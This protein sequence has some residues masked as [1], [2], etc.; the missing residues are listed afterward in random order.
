MPPPV[1]AGERWPDTRS[2]LNPL[3]ILG[4]GL[5]PRVVSAVTDAIGDEILS[6]RALVEESFLEANGRVGN[7]FGI[8]FDGGLGGSSLLRE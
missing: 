7:P 1:S 8:S 6:T 4:V 2:R 5:D 3:L